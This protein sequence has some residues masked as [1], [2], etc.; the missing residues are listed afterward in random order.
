MGRLDIH[1]L[2]ARSRREGDLRGRAR[3]ARKVSDK[4]T[5]S[6]GATQREGKHRGGI[7]DEGGHVGDRVKYAGNGHRRGD[8]LG[9][10]GGHVQL[11]YDGSDKGDSAKKEDGVEKH[12]E[13]MEI[14]GLGRSKMRSSAASPGTSCVRPDLAKANQGQSLNVWQLV[15]QFA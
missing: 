6:F 12:G 10:R 1:H 2:D 13:E 5:W 7:N 3:A 4:S 14:N 11:A 8:F 15:R 9:L